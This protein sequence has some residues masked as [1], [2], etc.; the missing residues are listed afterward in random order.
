VYAARKGLDPAVV[1]K[2]KKALLALNMNNPEDK[3]ILEKAGFDAVIPA[4][5]ADFNAVRR[6]ANI[7]ESG[8]RP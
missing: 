5:D 6:L 7:V 3:A 1:E 2:I 4:Q 8:G